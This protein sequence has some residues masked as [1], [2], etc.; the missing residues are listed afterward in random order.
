[1]YIYI[2]YRHNRIIIHIVKYWFVRGLRRT[3][4]RHTQ[5]AQVTTHL[6]LVSLLY[7]WS[8]RDRH[9]RLFRHHKNPIREPMVSSISAA[10]RSHG[11][12]AARAS[13]IWSRVLCH[14]S[15]LVCDGLLCWQMI[16]PCS[17]GCSIYRRDMEFTNA[18]RK[19]KYWV[20]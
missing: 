11:T 3:D 16:C 1:M 12:V 15:T 8:F 2:L 7:I 18:V 9:H 10:F 17:R 19:V 5:D 14:G 13:E 6:S 4:C 20:I